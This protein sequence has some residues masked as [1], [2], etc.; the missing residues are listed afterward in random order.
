LY[1]L[2]IV[3]GLHAVPLVWIVIGVEMLIALLFLVQVLE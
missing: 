2:S 1:S 3:D